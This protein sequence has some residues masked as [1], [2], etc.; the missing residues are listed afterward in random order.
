MQASATFFS[1]VSKGR[2]PKS[3]PQD[4]FV[5]MW[6]YH[7][8]LLL[9]SFTS[10]PPHFSTSPPDPSQTLGFGLFL[11]P[12]WFSFKKPFHSSCCK[13]HISKAMSFSSPLCF[14]LTVVNPGK[15]NILSSWITNMLSTTVDRGEKLRCSDPEPEVHQ[16]ST[17]EVH[18]L[19]V[20]C[21]ELC[22]WVPQRWTLSPT[23]WW[24]HC[25]VWSRTHD[26]DGNI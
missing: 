13:P 21:K 9:L 5:S 6:K 11:K 25:L 2:N 20:I 26:L 23:L 3:V 8:Q 17:P 24:I 16:V 15:R 18:S 1:T 7:T 10:S 19:M 14:L 22:N 4:F 12:V